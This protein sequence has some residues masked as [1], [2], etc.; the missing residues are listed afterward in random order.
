MGELPKIADVLI[1]H[2]T[3]EWLETYFNPVEEFSL[4]AIKA[5]QVVGRQPYYI[6]TGRSLR[7][8]SKVDISL[9]L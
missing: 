9:F 8:Q 4:P 6:I 3:F 7:S 1:F 2:R 5:F